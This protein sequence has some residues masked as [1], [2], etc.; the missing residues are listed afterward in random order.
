LWLR[1]DVDMFNK[2]FFI[3]G[4]FFLLF[5]FSGCSMKS[6]CEEERVRHSIKDWPKYIQDKEI[7]GNR[8]YFYS[9]PK[10]TTTG[11]EEKERGK[12]WK[13]IRETVEVKQ[14]REEITDKEWCPKVKRAVKPE[15]SI[16]IVADFN[17]G[18]KPNNLGGDFGAWDKEPKDYS[19]ICIDTFT[20]VIKKGKDGYSLQLYYDVKSSTTAYNGFWCE[21]DDTIDYSIF[22]KIGFWVKGDSNRGYTDIFKVELKNC[23]NEVAIYYVIGITDDW[24]EIVVPFQKFSGLTEWS[25]LK[26]F[27]IIFEDRVATEKEGAIYIDEIYF[28]K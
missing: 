6:I 11:E 17:S 14:Q 2:N 22:N 27:V 8:G 16:L 28:Q 13:T 18:T 5:T 19:Q 7:W 24:Q 15:E 9:I 23:I 25:L 26:E 4:L 3:L 10:K 12:S 21:L 20:P 1:G